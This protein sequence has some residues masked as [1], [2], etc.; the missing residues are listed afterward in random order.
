MTRGSQKPKPTDNL[1]FRISV[2][3]DKNIRVHGAKTQFKE[4]IWR[5]IRK[6]VQTE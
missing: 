2:A 4:M 1:I 5:E 3:R 6:L